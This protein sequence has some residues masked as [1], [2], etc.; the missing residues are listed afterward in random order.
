MLS[1]RRVQLT[2]VITSGPAVMDRVA[3][4]PLNDF[5]PMSRPFSSIVP[6]ASPFP[7]VV[8]PSFAGWDHKNCFIERSLC[9]GPWAKCFMPTI[10]F[11]PHSDPVRGDY[12]YLHFI[13]K[14]V[15]AQRGK[16]TGQRPHSNK[17]QAKPGSA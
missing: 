7:A 4:C 13:G 8:H 14:D 16:G 5:S 12:I 10:S 6:M 3:F 17:A 2:L 11:S 15:G 1:H 9:A